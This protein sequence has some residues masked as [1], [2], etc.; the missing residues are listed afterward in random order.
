MDEQKK[1]KNQRDNVTERAPS[2]AGSTD[3][4]TTTTRSISSPRP[5]RSPDVSPT[6]QLWDVV[7]WEIHSTDDWLPGQM[8]REV[9]IINTS[10]K[11]VCRCAHYPRAHALCKPSRSSRPG[12]HASPPQ[13][14]Q[15][16]IALIRPRARGG[17]GVKHAGNRPPEH[18]TRL[19]L[20]QVTASASGCLLSTL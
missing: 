19:S 14:S 12:F 1:K 4:V 16:P 6:G 8:V 17:G 10:H 2:H 5:P 18:A 9:Y 13:R 20:T 7:K 11:Y 3:R 15:T